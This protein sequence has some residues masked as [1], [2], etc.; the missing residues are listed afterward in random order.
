MVFKNLIVTDNLVISKPDEII[1]ISYIILV[2]KSIFFG[3][4]QE[5]NFIGENFPKNLSKFSKIYGMYKEKIKQ[6]NKFGFIHSMIFE[7]IKYLGLKENYKK[8]FLTILEEHNIIPSFN[9]TI[10][11]QENL[12]KD[13][14]QD[15]INFFGKKIQEEKNSN[16]F[17]DLYYGLKDLGE[18]NLICA[19]HETNFSE[20]SDIFN[21]IEIKNSK[22]LICKKF[23]DPKCQFFLMLREDMINLY[24]P[25]D[26]LIFLIDKIINNNS[27]T[28]IIEEYFRDKN[29]YY[30]N[31]FFYFRN[32]KFDI[33][34][35]FDN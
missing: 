31:L 7:I 33:D 23:K 24:H 26:L 10:N 8:D 14:V 17:I 13:L 21:K 4:S 34:F 35:I 6:L 32:Y 15:K 28:F 20:E 18:I 27:M 19:E 29:N 16:K 3:F 12:D 22:N 5:K 11:F 2:T 1:L 9:I 25:M 30:E